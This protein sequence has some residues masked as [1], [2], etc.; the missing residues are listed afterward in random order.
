M[1]QSSAKDYEKIIIVNKG[2]MQLIFGISF[3]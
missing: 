2:H 3:F 1:I